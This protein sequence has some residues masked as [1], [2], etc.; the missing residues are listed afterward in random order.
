MSRSHTTFLRLL[1]HDDK[2]AALAAAVDA[3]RSGETCPD[4]YRTDPAAFA[5][6]PGSPMAYWVSD[7]LRQK[8]ASLPPLKFGDR[9][10]RSG[11]STKNDFRFLIRPRALG[12]S[13]APMNLVTLCQPCHDEINRLTFVIGNWIIWLYGVCRIV[14]A[15][16]EDT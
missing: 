9:D 1:A 8:F 13:D 6:V 12:G 4:V 16:R 2:P 5:Q 10:L 14:R 11:G 3:L 15:R 7:G